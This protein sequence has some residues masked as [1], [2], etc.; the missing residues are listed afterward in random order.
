MSSLSSLTESEDEGGA[1]G[2]GM[3]A[4]ED[5]DEF[6]E[7]GPSKEFTPDGLIDTDVARAIGLSLVAC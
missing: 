5:V 1:A 7:K 4:Q 3:V 2:L 6:L